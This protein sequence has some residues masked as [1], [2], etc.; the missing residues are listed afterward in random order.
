MPEPGPRRGRRVGRKPVSS[1]QGPQPSGPQSLHLPDGIQGLCPVLRLSCH[2]PSS[3]LPSV[4]SWGGGKHLGFAPE[5]CLHS[6]GPRGP[7]PGTARPWS[8]LAG[9]PAVA[10]NSLSEGRVAVARA[11]VL[12]VRV[13]RLG[14]MASGLPDKTLSASPAPSP[15][16]PWRPALCLLARL[17][18]A[19]A[20]PV[21]CPAQARIE[22]PRFQRVSPWR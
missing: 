18:M 13:N 12:H 2:C 1:S 22:V 19:P 15:D 11:P 6:P 8:L 4:S 21:A 7:T 17:L 5:T 20:V 9:S 14:H 16:P 10:Q 3:G